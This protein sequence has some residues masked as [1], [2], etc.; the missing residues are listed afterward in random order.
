[1]EPIYGK[2]LMRK[3]MSTRGG[4]LGLV[5]E[6]R[7]LRA[8]LD[9]APKTKDKKSALAQP[10]QP[11]QLNVYPACPVKR[12]ACLS[13][14]KSL[15][16]L[17]HRVELIILGAYL[18]GMAKKNYQPRTHT[19]AHRQKMFAASRGNKEFK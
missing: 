18:T 10:V 6:L 8:S 3:N 1:L 11:V 2:A 12:G 17:F 14:V 15:L 4:I 9:T 19:E 13:G 7:G 5:D 16:H